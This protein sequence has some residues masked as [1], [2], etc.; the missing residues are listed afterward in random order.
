MPAASKSLDVNCASTT[1]VIDPET[2]DL[3][4]VGEIV[5][6]RLGKSISPATLWRW[7]RKGIGGVRLEVIRMGGRWLTTDKAF[8]E[9]LRAQTANA[10]RATSDSPGPGAGSGRTPQKTRELKRRGLIS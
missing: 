6:A 3:R 4:P 2:D 5:Q 8:A 10:L 1:S 7:A 9:F